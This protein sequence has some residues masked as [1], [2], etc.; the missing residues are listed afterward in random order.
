ML[1]L[2]SLAVVLS[3]AKAFQVVSKLMPGSRYGIVAL[4]FCFVLNIPVWDGVGEPYNELQP[5]TRFTRT[6]SS[7]FLKKTINMFRCRHQ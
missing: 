5:M 3:S 2:S 1:D 4:F 7:I 6:K